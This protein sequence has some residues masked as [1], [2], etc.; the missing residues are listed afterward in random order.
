MAHRFEVSRTPIRAALGRLECEGLVIGF[1]NKGYSVQKFSIQEFFEICVVRELLE[2]Y[3]AEIAPNKISE[4][5]IEQVKK[6]R[7]KF[8]LL[9]QK[10]IT[11]SMIKKQNQLDLELHT[12]ILRL[13]GNDTIT[14]IILNLREKIQQ[15]RS[16]GTPER[17]EKSISEHLRI[18][19]CICSGD[20][21]GCK[22]AMISHLRGV[23][24]DIPKLW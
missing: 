4:Q 1:P 8:Q 12:L 23:K 21:S 9:L 3:A 7:K 20:G 11:D 17:L 10:E 6:L 14:N 24:E 19:E 15:I 5:D 22:E 16:T 13:C 2:G 18:I